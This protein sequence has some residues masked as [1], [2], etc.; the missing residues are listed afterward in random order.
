MKTTFFHREIYFSG[1][2]KKRGGERRKGVGER[3]RGAGE[4]R[5]LP[6]VLPLYNDLIKKNTYNKNSFHEIIY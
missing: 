2:R 3:R 5:R 4:R 1:R 6:T